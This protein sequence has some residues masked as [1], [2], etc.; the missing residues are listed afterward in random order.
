MLRALSFHPLDPKF[1]LELL[2]LEPHL[3]QLGLVLALQGLDL[4]SMNLPYGSLLARS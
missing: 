3:V 4:F 2:V 1:F